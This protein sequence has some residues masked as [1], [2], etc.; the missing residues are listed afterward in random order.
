MSDTSLN[1][2][3]LDHMYAYQGV[4]DTIQIG[5]FAPGVWGP[6]E[7][8]LAFEDL[9]GPCSPAGGADC[10]YTDFVVIVESVTPQVPEPVSLAM[11]GTGLLMLGIGGLRRSQ[12]ARS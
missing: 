7:Y 2:D 1:G 9:L 8:I 12:R 10:D 4:G 5:L 3:G 11:V 6:N